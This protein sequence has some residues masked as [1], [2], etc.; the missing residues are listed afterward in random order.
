M[1]RLALASAFLALTAAATSAAELA[2]TETTLQQ[3]GLGTMQQMS[4]AD[5]MTVRG[6]GPFED[7][8]L[9]FLSGDPSL[10]FGSSP[11]MRDFS[12][13][14]LPGSSLPGSNLPGG[15]LPPSGGNMPTTPR[16]PTMTQ[17]RFDFTSIFQ[18]SIG[19]GSP[20]GM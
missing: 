7:R 15:S 1:K 18:S 10:P 14:D 4:D 13:P 5:G 6:K 17:S 20:G 9:A 19:L 11:A 12:F 8:W 2:V 16:G 3:M